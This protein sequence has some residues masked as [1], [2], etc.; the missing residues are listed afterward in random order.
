MVLEVFYLGVFVVLYIMM[1]VM[2]FW[3]F[4]CF[5]LVVYWFVL[6]DMFNV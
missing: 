2:D 1:V 3:Y 5:V 6:L 4:Y